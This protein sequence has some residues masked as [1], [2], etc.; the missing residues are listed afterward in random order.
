M[1]ESV[2]NPDSEVANKAG[3]LVWIDKGNLL[4]DMGVD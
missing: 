4:T 2:G 3:R 1:H